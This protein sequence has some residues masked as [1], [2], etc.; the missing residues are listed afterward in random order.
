[1]I[2]RV[3]Q[4]AG[5]TILMTTHV[6]E[7]VDEICDAVAILHHGRLAKSGSP[8]QFKGELCNLIS[9]QVPGYR[10]EALPDVDRLDSTRCKVDS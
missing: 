8:A 10:G 7:E 9:R 5:M 1:M 4:E 2:A 6:M 3:E